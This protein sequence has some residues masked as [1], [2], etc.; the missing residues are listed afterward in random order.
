MVV[1]LWRSGPGSVSVKVT[2][3]EFVV[4]VIMTMVAGERMPEDKVGTCML[5]HLS[6]MSLSVHTCRCS[7]SRR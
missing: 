4:N 1:K 7:G 3:Y 2:A 6:H 5:N